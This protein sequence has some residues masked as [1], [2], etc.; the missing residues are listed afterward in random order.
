MKPCRAL[1]WAPILGALSALLISPAAAADSRSSSSAQHLVEMLRDAQSQY[2]L[3]AV[4]CGVWMGNEE[5]LTTALGNSMT[6]VPATEDMHLRV[7]GV[8]FTCV[9]TVLLRLVD[10][11]RVSLDD[12]LSRWYPDLPQANAVT[13]RMLANCTCGY[14]DYVLSQPFIDANNRAPFRDWTPQELIDIGVATPLLYPP[15]TGWN[16]SHTNYVILG[17]VLQKVGG[18]PMRALLRRNIF[19][20]LGLRETDLPSTPEI[21]F[22]VL[23]AFSSERGIFEDS[24]YWN[25]S[26]TSPSG[27]MTSTLHDLGVI[28]RAL[29]SGSLLSAKSRREQIAPTTVGLGQNRAGV[30]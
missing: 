2:G 11:G 16:Y 25:P 30:Y 18:Q 20:P 29:G 26:W 6:G 4:L 5:L 24:T 14:P 19:A 15:G 13:L 23:H 9:A 28:A 1:L 17:E 27:R 10:Q 7:G 3:S 22:P 8:T 21:A 12:K